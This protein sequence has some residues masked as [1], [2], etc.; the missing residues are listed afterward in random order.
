MRPAQ[1]HSTAVQYVGWERTPN[2]T[3]IVLFRVMS[4]NETDKSRSR[5]VPGVQQGFKHTSM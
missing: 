3:N 5:A 4:R 2:N 1:R